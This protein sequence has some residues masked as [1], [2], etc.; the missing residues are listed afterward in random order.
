MPPI[1]TL[2]LTTPVWWANAGIVCWSGIPRLI[3]SGGAKPGG[4]V[5]SPAYIRVTDTQW[6]DIDGATFPRTVGPARPDPYFYGTIQYAGA[7]GASF[8]DAYDSSCNF[9][10]PG[11][12]A[13]NSGWKLRAS[14]QTWVSQTISLDADSY[15]TF[16]LAGGKLLAIRCAVVSFVQTFNSD[17][18]DPGTGL[19]TS[20]SFPLGTWMAARTN[21]FPFT[22]T[23]SDGTILCVGASTADS[24][25]G[26]KTIAWSIFNGTSWSAVSTFSTTV[27]ANSDS[28][29]YGANQALAPLDGGRA[30]FVAVYYPSGGGA[31]VTYSWRFSGTAWSATGTAV[32][33]RS[34]FGLAG[35]YAGEAFLV[36]G[37][38]ADT[39]VPLA[40]IERYDGG[41]G[42]WSTWNTLPQAVVWPA[43]LVNMSSVSSYLFVVGGKTA[44]WANLG[45]G[46]Y[47]P[48]VASGSVYVYQVA[49]A[50]QPF[51]S[52]CACSPPEPVVVN[53]PGDNLIGTDIWLDVTKGSGPDR[54]VTAHGD[55]LLVKGR[56]ALRQSLLRRYLTNPG[57]W[58]SKPDYGA[59]ARMFVK[60]KNV[61]AAR[62]E[63][64]TRIRQQSLKDPRVAAVDKVTIAWT[65]TGRINV[66]VHVIP[67]GQLDRN[68]P[69]TISFGVG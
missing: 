45:L 12:T 69:V 60:A 39:A 5:S 63:L 61:K 1:A 22:T 59:G 14:D 17:I 3:V 9:I 57:E 2:P 54:H 23:L 27:P 43:C 34:G 35:N 21:Y 32:T 56:E 28:G 38:T 46:H 31:G 33:P 40:S 67:K 48:D 41:T 30:V 7:S 47:Q 25:A 62:D 49:R 18:Y 51:S 37:R 20:L 11:G 68:K 8:P 42:T 66:D 55:W 44:E 50:S 29:E 13:D 52:L 58:A 10:S 6:F 64:T 24:G 15:Q 4:V 65:A 16:G 26:T 19:W 53:A 36:G